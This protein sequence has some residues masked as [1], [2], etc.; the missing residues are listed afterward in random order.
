MPI[1]KVEEIQMKKILVIVVTLLAVY[2]GYLFGKPYLTKHFLQQQMK[3]LADK[4]DLKTD[5]EIVSELVSF[6]KERGLPLSRRDFKVMRH[7]GRTRIKVSYSQVVEI[8]GLRKDYKFSIDVI[9]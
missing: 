1:I 8:Q 5:R 4:A 9:S 3:G 6:S 7:D 2:V